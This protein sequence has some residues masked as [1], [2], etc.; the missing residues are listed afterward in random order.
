MRVLVIDDDRKLCRLIKTYLEPLGYEVSAVHTGPEGVEQATS[1]EWHAVILDVML[2]GL[3][4][5]EALKQIRHKSDV[6]VLMLTARGDEADRIVGLE[7]GADDYLP[8]TFSTR[9]LLARLRAVT[10][11]SRRT[12]PLVAT[13]IVVGPLRVNPDARTAVLGD[14]PLVL[15]PV[16]FDLL[17]S[18]AK[19][20]GRVKTREALLEEIR[21]R[22]YEVFDRSIDVHISAL[23]KKLGDDPKEPRLIKTV[24]GVGYMMVNPED[25]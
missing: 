12:T 8:K 11:R 7:I 2:P 3:D 22:P 13:E 15:T 17:A 24:W 6:P 21:E 9:E 16:E 19:A 25:A 4:G 5:F 18:L 23:R 20:C 10:R 14:H 1:G